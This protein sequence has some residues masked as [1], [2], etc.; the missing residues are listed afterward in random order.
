ML[1]TTYELFGFFSL[2]LRV[3]LRTYLLT[4]TNSGEQKLL[5]QTNKG[6]LFILKNLEVRAVNMKEDDD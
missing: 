6:V 2:K 5:L 4:L 1:R 3:D